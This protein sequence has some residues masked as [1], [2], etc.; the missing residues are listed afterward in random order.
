MI[1]CISRLEQLW[2]IRDPDAVDICSYATVQLMGAVI[3][4]DK[5][6]RTFDVDA[7]QWT[8]LQQKSIFPVTVYIPDTP[9]YS[10]LDKVTPRRSY[11]VSVFGRLTS[12]YPSHFDGDASESN[13]RPLRYGVELIDHTFI[14]GGRMASVPSESEFI[15]L[16]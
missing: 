13:W 12:V 8:P 16:I 7:A 2:P 5:E 6:Q 1:T 9:R 15:I 11:P 3:K 4:E 10:N 14:S